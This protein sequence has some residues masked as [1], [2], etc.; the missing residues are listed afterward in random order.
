MICHP[1]LIW[2][3]SFGE[4]RGL[5]QFLSLQIFTAPVWLSVIFKI[6]TSLNLLNVTL[7]VRIVFALNRSSAV[8]RKYIYR[9]MVSCCRQLCRR[10]PQYLFAS[11]PALH[12]TLPGC[13]SATSC[14]LPALTW[15][16]NQFNPQ[17][18]RK[19]NQII[20]QFNTTSKR[21]RTIQ[22]HILKGKRRSM[23]KKKQINKHFFS[24]VKKICSHP[25]CCTCW[26]K[27]CLGG[28]IPAHNN[29][30]C[31]S[32]IFGLLQI[33]AFPVS[34][35]TAQWK[36]DV[37]TTVRAAAQHKRSQTSSTVRV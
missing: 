8:Q 28:C 14:S 30:S 29:S 7:A 2:N 22:F 15:K 27:K 3:L 24:Q 13:R 37:Q 5:S 16:T 18:A 23:C 17:Q 25:P 34:D 26:Q 10:S 6:S 31:Y 33:S 36:P 4:H 32:L 35:L 1:L 21:S 20:I 19:K 9:V 12:L 11:H